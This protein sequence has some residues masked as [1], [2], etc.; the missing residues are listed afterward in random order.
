MEFSMRALGIDTLRK[1]KKSPFFALAENFTDLTQI[2]GET[3]NYEED[4]II[5]ASSK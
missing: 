5:G 3:R 1:T 2:E 4:Y